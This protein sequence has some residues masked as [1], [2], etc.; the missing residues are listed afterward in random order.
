MKVQNFL[1]NSKIAY[2]SDVQNHIFIHSRMIKCYSP[3]SVTKLRQT[4]QQII[5][6]N[7]NFTDQLQI[8]LSSKSSKCM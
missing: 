8:C 5:E 2:S 1:S 7:K 4:V 6:T 3:V